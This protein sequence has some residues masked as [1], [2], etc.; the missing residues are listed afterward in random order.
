MKHR[1]PY[2]F[3]CIF[4]NTSLL[5]A[6]ITISRQA[7]PQ[8]GDSLT[9]AID[10]LPDGIIITPAG[11][12]QEWDFRSLKSD[13]Y[14]EQVF[15]HPDFGQGAELFP[16]AHLMSRLT[17]R[18]ENYWQVSEERLEILGAY[19]TDT[20]G[21]GLTL[22]TR[23]DQ[24]LTELEVPL[25]ISDTTKSNTAF[26]IPFSFDDLP[27]S[28]RALLPVQPDSIRISAT[29]E[30]LDVVDAW[31]NVLL[32]DGTFEVLRQRRT[33]TL[34]FTIEAKIFLLDWQDIT[35]LVTPFFGQGAIPADTLVS[36]RFL[37]NEYSAPIVI[38]TLDG[39]EG[40]VQNVQFKSNRMLTRIEDAAV[41]QPFLTIFPN[42]AREEIW[43]RGEGLGAGEYFMQFVSM[44]G[45]VIK[46]IRRDIPE[47]TFEQ[48]AGLSDLQAGSYWFML[49]SSGGQLIGQAQLLS[50]LR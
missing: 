9:F 42:P 27:D 2:L 10:N 37:S 49:R 12:E 22:A 47:G 43:I 38:C 41:N 21:L 16:E 7:F 44:D 30:R 29:V 17:D 50:I 8:I 28:L 5:H 25:Q 23:F 4:F 33:E 26:K 48:K 13:F 32:A 35:E 24:P 6:Q 20:F 3:L 31:G 15:E 18:V 39:L 36:Y 14:L 1:L 19:G 46:Q 40:S 11:G 34:D 45:R